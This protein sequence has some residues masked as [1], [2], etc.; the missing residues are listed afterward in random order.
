[1]GR[2]REMGLK[3]PKDFSLVT[4]GGGREASRM[5]LTDMDQNPQQIGETMADLLMTSLYKRNIA[6]KSGASETGVFF[7]QHHLVEPMLHIR[8]SVKEPK[9]LS[10]RKRPAR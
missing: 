10:E 2:A 7:P 5:G 9:P 6:Q 3:I 8:E 4:I 1:M